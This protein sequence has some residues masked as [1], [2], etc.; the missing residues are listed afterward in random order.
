MYQTVQCHIHS[1]CC[2]TLTSLNASVLLVSLECDLVH[3][4]LIVLM[5]NLDL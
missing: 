4:C 2:E 1:H 5:H 3:V